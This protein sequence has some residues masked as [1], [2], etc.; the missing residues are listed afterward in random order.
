ML[1]ETV[2]DINGYLKLADDGLREHR[3]IRVTL[4]DEKGRVAYSRA[5]SMAE[6]NG[7]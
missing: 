5:Y 1:T 3:Y 7:K 4:M 2:F 6:I